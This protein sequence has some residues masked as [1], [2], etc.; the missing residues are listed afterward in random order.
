MN[1]YIEYDSHCVVS[2]YVIA[3]ARTLMQMAQVHAHAT[4]NFIPCC[5]AQAKFNETC[6]L[7][8]GSLN[9]KIAMLMPTPEKLKIFFCPMLNRAVIKTV[10]Y[11]CKQLEALVYEQ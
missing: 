9:L 6:E 4:S 8:P 2:K 7:N 10:K 11:H 5:D 1:K 3:P